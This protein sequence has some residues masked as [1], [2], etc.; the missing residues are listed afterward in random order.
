MYNAVELGAKG[1]EVSVQ[2]RRVGCQGRR[3]E[4]TTPSR[5]VPKGG[6][7]SVQRRLGGCQ[8]RRGECTTPSSWV[9]G[10]ER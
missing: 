2:R 4:C 5:W 6:E 7:V 3:G 10:E 1:G 9:P 8:G